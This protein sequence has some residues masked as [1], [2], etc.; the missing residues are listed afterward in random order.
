[1]TRDKPETTNKQ[2]NK[3][4]ATPFH[5][6]TKPFCEP[7]KNPGSVGS[8]RAKKCERSHPHRAFLRSRPDTHSSIVITPWLRICCS[9]QQAAARRRRPAPAAP[10]GPHC[11]RPQNRLAKP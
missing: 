1:M 8:P 9:A 4:H 5:T 2:N 6:R 10:L 11:F 3:E 7:I